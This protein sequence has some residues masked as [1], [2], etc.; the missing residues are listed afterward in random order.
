M[1]VCWRVVVGEV[2]G[3]PTA[4]G[5]REDEGGGRADGVGGGMWG[6]SL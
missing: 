2:M 6:R 1:I 3:E 5:E 4:D